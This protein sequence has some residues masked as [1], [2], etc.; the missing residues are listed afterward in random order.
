MTAALVL[1]LQTQEISAEELPESTES[2][3]G[4]VQEL[5]KRLPDELD[6]WN[7]EGREAS[8]AVQMFPFAGR[9]DLAARFK[10][11]RSKPRP[12][13]IVQGDAL[14]T[15]AGR[16][17]DAQIVIINE[18]HDQPLHRYVIEKLGLKL[19]DEFQLFGAETFDHRAL[20]EKQPGKVSG[21]LGFYSNEPI[22]GRQLHAL[23]GAGYRF[24]AYEI[25]E[26]QK[27]PEDSSTA[28]RV[29][30]REE[31]QAEN[32]IAEVLSDNPEQRILVHVGYSHALEEPVDNFGQQIEWFA[33]RLKRKTGIDP[34][35]ISQTHCSVES[36]TAENAAEGLRIVD[37]ES[38][39]PSPGAI[40]IVLAHP[41]LR[42]EQKRP[43]WR[44]ATGDIAIAVPDA[45]LADDKR[46]VIE[47]RSPDQSLDEVPVERLLLYPGESAPLLL[48]PGQWRLTAWN[49]HGMQHEPIDVTT[50]RRAQ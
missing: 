7:A 4:P 22:F 9:E 24:V 21:D 45:F 8:I 30:T 31:A 38:A 19:S 20:E 11:D 46:V 28:E 26:H 5:F 39:L 10:P 13:A 16:A 25:R 17:R 12:C 43:V 18:A 50:E 35:T 41:P 14:E 47:A 48:P 36:A 3:P 34:L 49:Q 2:P 32:L 29:I 40:D 44:F 42:F 23:E 37:A 6:G 1:L 33:A 27:Q 15:I